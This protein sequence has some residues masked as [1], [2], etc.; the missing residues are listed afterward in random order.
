MGKWNILCD[1]DGTIAIED[2]TDSLLER[3]AHPDWARLER[4]WREGRI[5]SAECMAGQV[6]L[7]DASREEIDAHLATLRI[8]PAFPAFVETV[9]AAGLTLRVVSD[10][11][12][13]AIK[14]ILG[15]YGLSGLPVQANRLVQTG[16]RSWKL[17]TPFADPN[18]RVKS[19]HCKCV[20]AV[21]AHN[22]HGRVLLVG[23]GASDFCAA[24]EADFV[25][26]KH[27]LI[28]HCRHAGIP[29]VSIVGF[30]DAIGSLPALLAGKLHAPQRV[31]VPET[32][33]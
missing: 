33:S 8:D 11:L 12:D 15:R 20:G 28:E 21:R 5:G 17:E 10:G 31:L 32:V 29:H 16:P 26:A 6:A 9:V 24:G 7:L 18:C 30:A 3:F 1:F 2:A 23:D 25:F 22:K 14:A 27:R 19:G 4:E 13:Y